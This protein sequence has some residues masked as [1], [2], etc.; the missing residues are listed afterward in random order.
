LHSDR[1]QHCIYLCIFQFFWNSEIESFK[2]WKKKN[3]TGLHVAHATYEAFDG[4]GT[5]NPTPQNFASIQ[6]S[7]AKKEK[8]NYYSNWF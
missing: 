3:K 7:L 5:Y 4:R 1:I 8:E 6:Y 2:V